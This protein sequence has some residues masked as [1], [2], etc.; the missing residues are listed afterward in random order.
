MVTINREKSRL[1]R[2]QQTFSEQCLW[3][4]LRNRQLAG[5]KFHRQYVIGHYIVDFVCRTKKLIVEL[6]GAHHVEGD[7]VEY[8]QI[9]TQ[10]FVAQGYRV[11]R[12]W[13][14]ELESTM[15]AVLKS[16]NEA[17]EAPLPSGE[18]LG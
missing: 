11:L 17:L 2:Q 13:N 4:Q 10:F 12:F 8:D 15:P 5:Y 9:R 6:D 7:Q 1:L 16:I 14:A 3:Q 18:G